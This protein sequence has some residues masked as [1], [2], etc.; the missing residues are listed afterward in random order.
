MGIDQVIQDLGLGTT[1]DADKLREFFMFETS[2]TLGD[3]SR[4]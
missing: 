2:V 1:R 3:V 4:P